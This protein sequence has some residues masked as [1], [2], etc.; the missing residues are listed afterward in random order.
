MATATLSR[1]IAGRKLRRERE[2]RH[3]TLMN[4]AGLAGLSINTVRAAEKGLASEQSLRAIVIVLAEIDVEDAR[5][6]KP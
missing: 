5:K 3:L 6:D 2:R 4:V 1:V